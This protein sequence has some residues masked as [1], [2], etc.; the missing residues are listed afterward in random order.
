MACVGMKNLSLPNS[1]EV[2]GDAAFSGCNQLGQITLPEGLK[3][4]GPRAFEGCSCL[5][6]V[7]IPGGVSSAGEAA[8]AYCTQ[9][10]SA[11]IGEGV[12]KVGSE[13]FS[14]C[15][16]LNSVSLPSTLTEISSGMFSMCTGLESIVLP[17]KIAVIGSDAFH[18]CSNLKSIN[19]PEGVTM[20]GINA[21]ANC[22]RLEEITIPKSVSVIHSGAFQNCYELNK[23]ISHLE[24]PFRLDESAFWNWNEEAQTSLF[25]TAVLYVPRGTKTI[26]ETATGW[27]EFSQIVEMKMPWQK[28]VQTLTLEEMP[29]LTYGDEPYQLPTQTEQGL[30][31]RWGIISDKS[32]VHFNDFEDWLLV[33]DGA[34]TAWLTA[35]QEGSDEYEPFCQEYTLTVD[36][37]QLTVSAKDCTKL[38]G[39]ENPELEI[40]YDGFVYG[41]DESVLEV[42]PTVYTTATKDSP[43]GEYPIIV[44]GAESDNYGFRYINGTLTVSDNLALSN[45]LSI[46]DIESRAGKQVEL[47]VSLTNDE[48]VVGVSFTLQLPDGVSVATDE[49]GEP[50]CTLNAE[51]MG[52]KQFS[53]TTMQQADGSWG[54]RI[55]AASECAS[56]SGTEGNF[57]TIALHIEAGMEDGQYELR[58]KENMLS[59]RKDGDEVYSVPTYDATA[60]LTLNSIIMGDV[61]DD[62]EVDLSDAIMVTYYS[63]NVRPTSFIE[64]AADMNG[65]GSIDLSDAIMITYIS[66]GTHSSS[67]HLPMHVSQVVG[68]EEESDEL[69]YVEPVSMQAGQEIPLEI[70]YTIPEDMKAFVG[71]MFFVDLPE[72]VSLVEDVDNPGYPWY[73]DTVGAIAKM[74]I[75]TTADNGFAA[76]PQSTNAT[77]SGNEGVLM[78]LKLRCDDSLLAGTTLEGSIRKPSFNLRDEGYNVTKVVLPDMPFTITIGQPTAIQDVEAQDLPSRYYDLQGRKLD[79]AQRGVNIIRM[80]D[81]STRKVVMK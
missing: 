17:E 80:N 67:Q 24:N 9:M 44:S 55:A 47:P 30:P 77:I 22:S 36:K 66:L 29:M 76:T 43:A 62:E 68:H 57:M 75:T 46:N 31:L 71:F 48:Q 8:F 53:M 61:N 69:M 28:D 73:D 2:I 64:R 19:I 60:T 37:A 54:F 10:E 41:E 72:G 42:R 34:G 3:R 20:F 40:L 5:K 70:S 74:N 16:L 27:K 63:L 6:K 59:V 49:D 32:V 11:I 51:R 39:E 38:F 23:V 18:W 33:I 21:F 78:R 4:I 50:I 25:S 81:G 65:D 1:L 13:M 45:F 58:L 26:Y 79:D 35:W 14:G 7:S 52:N 12:S 15:E 56:I